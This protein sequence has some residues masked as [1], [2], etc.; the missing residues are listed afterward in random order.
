MPKPSPAFVLSVVALFVSLG[1]TGY[2]ATKIAKGSIGA[3][4]LKANA[5]TADKVRNGALRLRHFKASERGKLHGAA[6]ARGLIGLTGPA[7][8]RGLQGLVGP[9]GV[10]GL[11]G[12]Q[13]VPGDQGLPGDQGAARASREIRATQATQGIQALQVTQALQGARGWSK[14]WCGRPPHVPCPRS[15]TGTVG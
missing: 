11:V 10:R 3:K 15:R 13:G 9:A 6:G 14:W 7:G 1:G 8:S 2:A 5:V 4:E 12:D